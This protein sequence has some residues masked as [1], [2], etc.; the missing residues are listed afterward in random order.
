[1]KAILS[2]IFFAVMNTNAF[3]QAKETFDLITYTPPKEW[4]SEK[5]GAYVGYS[6]I[7]QKDK[8]WCQL[9]IYKST[10]SKGNIDSDFDS[11]WAILAAKPYNITEP[12]QV[13]V[14]EADGWK[15]KSGSGKFLFNNKDAGAILTTF[16]GYGVCISILSITANQRYIKDIEAFLS[17]IDIKKPQT[18]SQETPA[19][20]N[21]NSIIGIWVMGSGGQQK[22][23]DYKN[24]HAASNYG[25]S[26]AQ[27]VFNSDGTYLFFSKTFKQVVDKILLVKENGTY[28]IS[29][30]TITVHPLKSVIE[31]WTKKD[32]TDKWG[33]L[34]STQNRTIEKTT[35]RYTNHYFSGIQLWNLVLQADKTTQRDGPFSSN[36][37]FSNAWYYAPVSLNNT[38]IDLPGG[39]KIPVEEIKKDPVKQLVSNENTTLTGTW[40]ISASDQSDWRVKNGVMSTIFRQYTFSAN[41]TYTFNTKIFDPLLNSILLGRENGTYQI[42]DDLI[43]IQPQKSVLEEWSKKDGRDE[44]GKLLKSQNIALEKIAYRFTK[45]Y[46][47]DYN[48]WQLI[49]KA[50]NETKRDGP[51]NGS[52][53][54]NTWIYIITSAARP[55]IKLPN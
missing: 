25:Y 19:S 26:K 34:V 51:F 3:T 35:Y 10:V 32:G 48:E 14:E 31:A 23:D 38:A 55:V 27:Y 39:Q 30:N 29:G 36:T 54:T 21:T 8:S 16:S 28:Q 44:W 11:E 18:A 50:G 7:D 33:K 20:A 46:I 4:K 47:A 43:T 6:F 5:T 53:G 42:S 41:G 45:S 15:I 17:S 22:Y 9:A 2:I 40:C 24:A 49:L 37:T 12:P 1:M 13:A 52:A